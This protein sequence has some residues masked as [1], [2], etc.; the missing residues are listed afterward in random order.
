MLS[1]GGCFVV[2]E[3]SQH[4]RGVTESLQVAN[5]LAR[6]LNMCGADVCGINARTKAVETADGRQWLERMSLKLL[7]V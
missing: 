4:L 5:L 7:H 3:P 1:T 6:F 2:A